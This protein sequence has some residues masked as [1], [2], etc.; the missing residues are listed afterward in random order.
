M[1]LALF[2]LAPGIA[3]ADGAVNVPS[4]GITLPNP[5]QTDN[6][7]TLIT[8]VMNAITMYVAPP[9][10][11]LMVII[12]GFMILTAGGD[13]EKVKTGKKTLIWTAVGFGIILVADLLLQL[14]RE[15]LN[16]TI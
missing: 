11:V 3:W 13:P 15:L 14:I 8:S 12:G 10:A 1:Q 6:I 7:L 16:A 5:L 9:I 2:I 4:G